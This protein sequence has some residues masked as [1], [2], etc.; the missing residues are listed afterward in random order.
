[1]NDFYFFLLD[2]TGDARGGGTMSVVEK[3]VNVNMIKKRTMSVVE[4]QSMSI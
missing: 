3:R 4:K 1:V 2:M